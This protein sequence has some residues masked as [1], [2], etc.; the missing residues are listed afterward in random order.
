MT[1]LGVAI[2]VLLMATVTVYAIRL[3]SPENAG[4]SLT[5]PFSAAEHLCDVGERWL[6]DGQATLTSE[7]K[8]TLDAMASARLI[9]SLRRVSTVG[10]D[11][12]TP[13]AVD[14]E[15]FAARKTTPMFHW[16]SRDASAELNIPVGKQLEGSD[17]RYK[18]TWKLQT[19]DGVCVSAYI[20]GVSQD[21]SGSSLLRRMHL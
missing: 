21:S 12:P 7:G 9:G 3:P 18:I 1:K 13:T 10:G 8:L 11:T 14:V 5:S 2:L 20:Q 6:G 17:G 4:A 15:L 16:D 19:G